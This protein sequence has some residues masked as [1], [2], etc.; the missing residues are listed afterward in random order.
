MVPGVRLATRHGNDFT[1]RFP[2]VAA[3]VATLPGRSLSNYE[4]FYGV[5]DL[6][7]VRNV[8]RPTEMKIEAEL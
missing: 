7:F 4:G 2:F 6:I 8:V 1:A 3:V 5:Y